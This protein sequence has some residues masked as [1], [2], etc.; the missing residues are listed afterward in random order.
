[1]DSFDCDFDAGFGM[2][3]TFDCMDDENFGLAKSFSTA[4]I[5]IIQPYETLASAEKPDLEKENEKNIHNEIRSDGF[6]FK[7]HPAED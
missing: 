5:G 3:T 4:P 2:Q 1:M 7:L 6:N